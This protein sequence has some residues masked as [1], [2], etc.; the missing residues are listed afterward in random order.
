[1]ASDD[2]IWAS[3]MAS[4]GD[5]LSALPDDA[6]V[7]VLSHLVTDEAVRTSALSSRWRYVHEG[8]P[9]V[10]LVDT[11]TGG[12]G[13]LKVCFDHQV[14]CAILGKGVETP[15]R[16]LHVP[17]DL[18]DQWI[19][20]AVA[21]GVEDLDIDLR[22][23]EAALDPLCPFR[24]SPDR[25]DSLMYTVTPRQTFRCRT[26][27]RLRLSCWALDLPGSVDMVSLET[28]HLDRVT[29]RDGLL[30]LLLSSCPRLADLTLEECPSVKE[31]AVTSPWL[32]SFAMICCHNATAVEL[33]TTY[34]R[35][36]HYKGSLPP[37]ESS[38]IVVAN[39]LAVAAVRIEICHG[40]CG[41]E[42]PEV[43]PVMALIGRCEKLARLDLCLRLSVAY[44]SSVLSCVLLELRHLRQLTLEGCLVTDD[45]APSVAA[46]LRNTED[47]EVL[48]LLPRGPEPPK[49]GTPSHD[50]SN[51]KPQQTGRRRRRRHRRQLRVRL[52]R[53]AWS[54][55]RAW[56]Y[57]RFY[58]GSSRRKRRRRRRQL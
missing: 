12:R 2:L 27:R 14:A 3:K 6:L 31:I 36:L 37:R 30:Q 44:Y 40:H 55:M 16:V 57:C 43:A 10:D 19:A 24:G 17:Y 42:S 23:D 39:Y 11:K 15:I 38:F 33:R 1:M 32:R 18:L 21:S 51:A 7:R 49:E 8:V 28:L 25:D 35:S 34:L 13:D 58:L 56:K 5:R 4:G 29:A 50:E 9:A 20:T 41:E 53:A 47:L 26:L 45:A 48:S 52:Q 54:P 46:L 22:Y